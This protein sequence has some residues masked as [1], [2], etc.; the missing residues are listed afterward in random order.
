MTIRMRVRSV[1]EMAILRSILLMPLG[2]EVSLTIEQV[3]RTT[4]D[5]PSSSTSSSPSPFSAGDFA[6]TSWLLRSPLLFVLIL[7]FFLLFFFFGALGI[8]SLGEGRSTFEP[9]NAPEEEVCEASGGATGDM[10]N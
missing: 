7:F 9:G 5:W 10:S 6:S 1:W 8:V 4:A 2:L 3:S